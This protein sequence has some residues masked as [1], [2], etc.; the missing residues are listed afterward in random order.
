M[1]AIS[2]PL[3]PALAKDHLRPFDI[4]RDLGAVAD[5]V[6]LCFADTLDPDGRDYLARMRSAASSTSIVG[7][8]KGWA[9]V[10]MAGFVWEEDGR[11]VG[12]ASLIP[13]FLTG[14]RSFLIANVAVHPEYRRRGIARRL[15]E[16]AVAYTRERG[17]PAAWLHV[18]AE[19]QGALQLYRSLGFQ[20]RAVRTTW[21]G[22]PDYAA[23]ENPPGIRFI[24]PGG[25]HWPLLSAWLRSSYPPE[26]SWH[27]PF[28]QNNLR[29]GFFG[30]ISRFLYNTYIH[31]WGALRG[32]RLMAAAAWQ[33]TGSHANVIW[34]A[35]PPDGENEVVRLLL[36]HVR[37]HAPTRRALAL[38][39]PAG[40]NDQAIR[41]AGFVE[42]QTLVWMSL[43]FSR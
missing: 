30:F 12:N 5:L 40:Q 15:T 21:M 29:P 2:E 34:L 31:Q 37:H 22:N 41:N 11:I 33:A 38:D 19:N 6:E 43:T 25:Q 39:Y 9:S 32:G 3:S 24:S 1:A 26:L 8:A 23:A 13:Y 42:Q 14:R 28:H 16:K 10:P 27:M 4:R 20:D 35:A 36:E 7:M 18:R 17:C